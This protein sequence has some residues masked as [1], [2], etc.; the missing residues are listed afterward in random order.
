LPLDVEFIA[1]NDRHGEV[2]TIQ[3][4][5]VYIMNDVGKTIAK[6]DFKKQPQALPPASITFM[7]VAGTSGIFTSGT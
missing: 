3:D 4:G 7:N 5:L 1:F 2:H 6:Y